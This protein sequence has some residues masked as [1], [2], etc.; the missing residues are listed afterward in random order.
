MRWIY[1]AI[2][3]VFVAALIIFMFQNTQSVDVSFLAARRHL[4][5]RRSRPRRLCARGAERRQPL[6]AAAAIGCRVA[7]LRLK[8]SPVMRAMVLRRPGER[9]AW[10]SGPTRPGP[11]QIRVRI[12]ACGVCRTDLHV[13]DGELPDPKLPIV[14]GHEIVG[15]VEAAGEGVEPQDSARASASPGSATP[16]GLAPIAGAGARTSATRRSSPAIRATAATPPIR[17]PTRLSSFRCPTTSIRS[18]PRR[19]SAPA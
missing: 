6:C 13:V 15:R 7:A 19:C 18:R 10:R 8:A 2:V 11:G 3:V 1:L 14:P 5:A 9:L 12:E 17:S 4:A 16:A